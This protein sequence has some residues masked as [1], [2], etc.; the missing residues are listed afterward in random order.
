MGKADFQ[1]KMDT[2]SREITSKWSFSWWVGGGG[3]GGGQ[4]EGW[5]V[6]V[7]GLSLMSHTLQ[8]KYV[9]WG[10]TACGIR[11]FVSSYKVS[12]SCRIYQWTE[13]AIFRLW[14]CAS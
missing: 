14:G 8:S 4:E 13:Y 2:F 9:F 3:G 7:C 6:C 10:K 12:A 11:A 1:S 5:S